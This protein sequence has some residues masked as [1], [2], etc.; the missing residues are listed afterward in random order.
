MNSGT[1]NLEGVRQVGR[2]F[3][4][5][6]QKLGFQTT[7]IP[8]DHVQRSGHLVA[9]WKGSRS[10]KTVLLIGH[11]DTVFEKDSAF[12]KFQRLDE[13]RVKGPGIYDMKGGIVAMLLSLNAL[14]NAGLLDHQHLIIVL[15]GDE[16][17]AGRDAKGSPLASRQALID[18]AKRSDYALGFEPGD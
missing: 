1:F 16:E 12:Q 9:E 3:S 11:L 7:W 4:T 15:T 17:R 18:A 8:L 2:F 6:L 5:P 13:D 10:K 14:K